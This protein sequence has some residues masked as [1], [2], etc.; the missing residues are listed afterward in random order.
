MLTNK[1]SIDLEFCPLQLLH[2][3]CTASIDFSATATASLEECKCY[4]C[5][6][7]ISIIINNNYNQYPESPSSHPTPEARLAAGCAGGQM[8]PASRE[9]YL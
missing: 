8:S 2:G 9:R 5:I 1:K 6:T 3:C 4:T 7:G